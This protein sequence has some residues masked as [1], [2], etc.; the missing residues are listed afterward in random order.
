MRVI[1]E[2]KL[3]RSQL[4]TL[5]RSPALLTNRMKTTEKLS[6]EASWKD[7]AIKQQPADFMNSHGKKSLHLEE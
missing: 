3:N 2:S 4:A 6:M 5:R 1:L 7:S